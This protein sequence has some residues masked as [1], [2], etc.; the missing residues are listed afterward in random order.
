MLPLSMSF[1]NRDDIAVVYEF[2][3]GSFLSFPTVLWEAFGGEKAVGIP[4]GE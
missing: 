3:D 2:S 1:L 4:S